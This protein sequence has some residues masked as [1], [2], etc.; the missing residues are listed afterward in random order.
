MCQGGI[1]ERGGTARRPAAQPRARTS[2]PRPLGPAERIGVPPRPEGAGRGTE[3]A[4]PGPGDGGSAVALQEPASPAKS[5]R[6]A[7]AARPA[8][9]I[10]PVVQGG[11]RGGSGGAG[12]VAI[13]GVAAVY[14]RLLPQA[15][16]VDGTGSLRARLRRTSARREEVR[17]D[18]NQKSLKERER[19]ISLRFS[20]IIFW[21]AWKSKSRFRSLPFSLRKE[22]GL[23]RT[24]E[25]DP[26]KSQKHCLFSRQNF[27]F[28]RILVDQK[29]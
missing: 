6:G 3:G 29:T 1:E 19:M 2:G 17:E 12:V 16:G 21:N 15:A 10:L 26:P 28:W 20:S 24:M 27:S 18:G 7:F 13:G 25:S 9:H 11:R 14:S 5:G 23:T 22:C 4:G 8:G